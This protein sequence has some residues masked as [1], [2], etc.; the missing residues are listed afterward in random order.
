MKVI[1]LDVDGTLVNYEGKVPESAVRAVRECQKKGNRVYLTTGRS[2]AEIYPS[3][4]DI[5]LDGMIGG[6][7]MYIEERG[8]VLLDLAMKKEDVVRAVDWMHKNSLGFYLESKNGLF[9]SEN[10]LS[11]ACGLFGGDTEENRQRL[12]AIMPDMIY[13]GELYRDDVA[14]ISFYLDPDLLEE[15]RAE[16]GGTL[17][18]GSWSASGQR[19]E[20][21]EFALAGM[22]KV[23]A[24]KALLDHLGVDRADTLAFGDAENDIQM[25][26][27]CNT[28]V[29]MGNAEEGLKAVA[30]HVA[31]HIDADGL[32][33][34]FAK[35]G[36]V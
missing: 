19:Q 18:V 32:W 35:Y 1:F 8:E 20:F 12:R 5:G 4:W 10:L 6:N 17:K 16:F 15:A 34:A 30:D 11:K 13:G 33:N 23:N 28:G 3:L 22:D 9:A 7:G 25:V 27:F 21:G 36:L 14:K 24:I 2:K 29:A 26:E 31:A